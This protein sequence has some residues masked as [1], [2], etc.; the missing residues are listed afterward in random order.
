MH[1]HTNLP[2]LSL[3]DTV[4][5]MGQTILITL[6]THKN[7]EFIFLTLEKTMT[8]VSV[9]FSPKVTTKTKT[10]TTSKEIQQ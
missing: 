9:L 3:Y 4:E 6:P 5:T 2:F 10:L 8:H 1:A 7:S